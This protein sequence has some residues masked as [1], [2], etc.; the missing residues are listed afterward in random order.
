M[1][2][3]RKIFAVG[4][5]VLAAAACRPSGGKD[6]Q[7]ET[8]NYEDSKAHADLSIKV[9]LPVYG[10]GA[11][12]DRIRA[13]LV[14]VMD[15]QLSHIGSYEEE[16]LFP[17][18]E[19][20]FSKTESLVMYY[21][22]KALEAIGQLSQEDYDERVNSIEENDGLT[23]GQRKEILADMPGWEYDF[24][25]LKDRE[26]DRYVVFLSQDYVYLGGAHG[27]VV[28]RGGLTFDKKEGA[29]V[30]KM[31]DSA[32]LD[33]VQPLLRKGLSQYFSDNEM[34]VAPEELDNILFLETGV[35]PFPAWTPYPSEEGLV[36]TYQQY[37]IAAYAAGMPE[38]T[39]PY[40]D[41]LSY[42]TPEAKALLDLE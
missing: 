4:L 18:F 12:A 16:R 2:T 33:A 25:L 13:S 14:E 24:S 15:G 29:L 31:V 1:K 11:A 19:G 5:A 23:D 6:L 42:L 36:F 21:R 17:A 20:D 3:M 35:I 8:L 37:E 40:A 39:V 28:G 27:G 7:T 10:Q 41:I 34:E 26:T 30:E 22:D 38:F 32:S 9:E